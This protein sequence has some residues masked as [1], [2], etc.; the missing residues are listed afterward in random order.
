M[1]EER[2]NNHTNVKSGISGS[3]LK[4]IAIVTMLID[5]I[6]AVVLIRMIL[7]NMA[8]NNI[9][10]ISPHNTLYQLYNLSRGIGRLAFPL[11]CFLLVEGFQRTGN[12]RKY[13]LRL[14]L[15]ALLSEIPFD[16]ALSSSVL[17]FS[18][19][20]VFFTLLIGLLTMMAADAVHHLPGKMQD[21]AVR[22]IMVVLRYPMELAVLAVGMLAA[23]LLRTDYDYKGVLCIMV[24][25]FFRWNKIS[26][27]IAGFCAF[28]W[29]RIAPL[30]FLLAGFYNG[31]RGMKLKYVF[32]LFYPLHLLI[33][34]G[35]CVAMGI[36]GYPAV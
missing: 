11:F 26:Q 12:R 2:K 5:H 15:F 22:S 29:E 13:A 19:Q 34:Y 10:G 32:Y 4:L 35:I 28:L 6:G 24:L 1:V 17:E 30:S 16:L 25:Y 23:V 7:D 27:C 9:T 36:H 20:N 14:G 31:E 33:L 21:E 8:A 18:Y 3:T